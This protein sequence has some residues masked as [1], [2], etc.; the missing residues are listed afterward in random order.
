MHVITRNEIRSILLSWKRGEMSSAEVH[1]W[2]EQRYAVDGFEPEDEIVNE[3]LSNLD[4][5]DINLVTPE[6]IPDFLR[7]LDYPRGQEAEALAFLDKRGESFD[8]Q[9]RMRHYADDP[10]YGRFCNPPP[11]E[12]PKPWWRFW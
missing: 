8:L 7:M 2:G 3:I 4:I 11:T 6:D 9:D 12:R 1:D 5:L 10:F